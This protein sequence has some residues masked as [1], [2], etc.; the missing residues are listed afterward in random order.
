MASLGLYGPHPLDHDSINTHVDRTGIG[1]YAHGSLN[2][3]GGVSVKRIGRSDTNLN[4]RIHDYVG[5]Y[6]HFKYGFFKTV[7]EC[8]EHECRMWHEFQPKDNPLHPDKPDG[9]DYPC[10]VAGCQ[11]C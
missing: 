8:Y 3:G 2:A 7:R 9:C 6:P 10:P 11:H 1:C 4:R 5:N